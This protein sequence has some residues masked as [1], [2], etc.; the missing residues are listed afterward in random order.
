[1]QEFSRT[2]QWLSDE[3]LLESYL[4]SVQLQLDEDFREQLLHEIRLRGLWQLLPEDPAPPAG[5]GS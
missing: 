2:L 3:M 5:Y 4:L 1:M